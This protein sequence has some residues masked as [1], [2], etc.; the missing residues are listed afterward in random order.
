MRGQ[1]G[2]GLGEVEVVGELAPGLLL[3]LPH[4]GDQPP[5]GPHPLPQVADQVGVLGE[6][7]DQNGPGA[8]QRGGGVGDALPRPT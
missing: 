8:L 5:A 3:A 4:L 1:A 6:T 7:L 2:E